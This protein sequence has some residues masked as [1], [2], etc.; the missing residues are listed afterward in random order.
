MASMI[1]NSAFDSKTT[2]ITA[3]GDFKQ[4]I[5]GWAGA[6]SDVF[7]QFKNDFSAEQYELICNHRSSPRAC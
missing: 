6:K 2:K 1:L 4:R 7:K 5:M 3:V